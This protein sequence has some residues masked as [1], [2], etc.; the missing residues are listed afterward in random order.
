MKLS[1]DQ[2]IA[3]IICIQS[4]IENRENDVLPKHFGLTNLEEFTLHYLKLIKNSSFTMKH[5]KLSKNSESDINRK[6]S[7]RYY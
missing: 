3:R 6:V 5:I 7:R 4:E 1:W 2:N